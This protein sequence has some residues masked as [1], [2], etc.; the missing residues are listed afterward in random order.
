MCFGQEMFRPLPGWPVWEE[1]EM[2]TFLGATKPT[3][4]QCVGG[5]AENSSIGVHIV[6]HYS[7]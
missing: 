5:Q 2:T 3:N 7:I 6:F 1:F 4:P